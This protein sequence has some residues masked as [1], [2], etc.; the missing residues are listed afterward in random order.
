MN[1]WFGRVGDEI[2]FQN[3][4]VPTTQ[5]ENLGQIP[6]EMIEKRTFPGW[7]PAAEEEI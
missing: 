2:L 6:S 3:I 7:R 4:Q 5:N 1:V